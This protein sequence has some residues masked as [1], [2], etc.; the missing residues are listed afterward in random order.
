[1]HNHTGEEDRIEPRKGAI[2][3][4]NGTPHEGEVDVACVMDLSGVAVPAID[5]DCIARRCG[6]FSRI[7]N[8]L[9]RELR[10]GSSKNKLACFLC[11]KAVLL[12]VRRV[13]HPVDKEIGC[14]QGN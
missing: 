13:P 4:S 5:E 11:S 1:M 8:G 10:E 7:F 6:Q 2:E 9:P 14:A 12:T 3:S